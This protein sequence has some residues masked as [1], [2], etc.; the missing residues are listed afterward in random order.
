MPPSATRVIA[1]DWLANHALIGTIVQVPDR[2]IT[3][4]SWVNDVFG[5]YTDPTQRSLPA[6]LLQ[7]DGERLIAL[8][9]LPVIGS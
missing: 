2:L 8:A 1:T 7:Q 5:A 3:S 4:L 9:P 6:E